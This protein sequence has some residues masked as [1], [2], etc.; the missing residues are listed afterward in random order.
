VALTFDRIKFTSSTCL[1]RFKR[2][3]HGNDVITTFF[4]L[5]G[6]WPSAVVEGIYAVKERGAIKK[7]DAVETT[8]LTLGDTDT[9]YEEN[10]GGYQC[11]MLRR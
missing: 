5:S 2:H 10:L 3:S 8:D 7:M 4:K 9:G 11:R 6:L 1:L